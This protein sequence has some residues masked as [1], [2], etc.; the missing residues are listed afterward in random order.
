MKITKDTLVD[1]L[2]EKQL[3][4]INKTIDDIKS[5]PE[6]YANNSLTKSQYEE[7]K[8]HACEIIKKLFRYSKSYTE[9]Q[10]EMLYFAYGLNIIDDENI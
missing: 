6:W 2:I 9:K 4:Y 7:F 5:D 3:S 1:H 8:V 10:F